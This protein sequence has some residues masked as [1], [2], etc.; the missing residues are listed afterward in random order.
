LLHVALVGMLGNVVWS[1]TQ[2]PVFPSGYECAIIAPR[3]DFS[4]AVTHTQQA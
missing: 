2:T 4:L 3:V 1:K